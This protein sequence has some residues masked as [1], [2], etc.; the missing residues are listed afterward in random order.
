MEPTIVFPARMV[1]TMDP[2]CPTAEAV[3]VRGDRF[4]AVGTVEELMAYPN[5]TLDDRYADR[6]LLPGFVEAHGHAGTG[7]VWEGTYVGYVDRT[8]PDG[9]FWPGC[10]SIEDVVERLRE[11]AAE[12]TD[13]DRTLMAWGLDPIYFPGETL[14]AAELDRA[15][16]TRPIYITHTS[17]HACAVNSAAMRASGIDETTEVEGVVKDA[18]GRPTGELHEFAAMGLVA[19]LVQ[20]GSILQIDENSIGRYA[21][22]GVNTGTTTLTDLGSM[23][24]MD[25]E[26]V[27]LYRSSVPADSPVR[28]NVF[29]F[30]AGAGPVSKSL[31]EAVERIVRLRETSTDRLRFGN[32]KLM[33]DGT[34]QGFT[35]RVLEPGYYGDQPN[36]M[37]NV[38]PEEYRAAFEAFHAAGLL[39]H[40][41]CNGDQAVQLFIDT[42][43]TV[44]DA[45]P[46]R[47]HRHTCTHSQMTRPAQYRRLAALGA[48]ANIFANHIWAWGDQHLDIT[49]GP[50]KAR[51]NNAAA[52]AARLGVPLSIHSDT[53]V[54]PLG[55][56]RT[57]KHA[58]TRLTQSGRVMGEHERISAAAALEAITIGA[59]Y[60][61][62]MDHEVGSIEP[63]K[64]A[65]LAVLSDD[66]FDLAPEEFER[67]H[68]YGTVVGGRHYASAITQEPPVS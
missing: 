42:L 66:P 48:C 26:G 28:L 33:L 2:A 16:D 34:L 19:H 44:L 15:T 49:M 67:I 43:Q 20:G 21:Q 27:E 5:A 65:D 61:L 60:M 17:G 56:L 53:P 63:G 7:S 30:G 45:H 29:H 1:R 9:R 37:W 4:R 25:D 22:D 31:P 54:T 59:A 51:R 57:A 40:V 18:D 14:T 68:V 62:K 12:L 46:R 6:V 24:L 38:T 52:T 47:D 13:P 35:A 55:P 50:D 58:I 8:D 10:R 41:H 11:G 3:A 36:G 39:I 32:V 23:I 64:Y